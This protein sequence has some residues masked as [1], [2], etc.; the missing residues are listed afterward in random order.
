[1][2]A[3]SEGC[4]LYYLP[5]PRR[6]ARIAAQTPL[7]VVGGLA[8]PAEVDGSRLDVDVHQV[9][10]DLALDVVLNAVDEVTASHVDHLDER[11][12]PGRSEPTDECLRG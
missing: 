2:C 4:P 1:M 12:L 8:V 7:Q 3:C 6:Q 10:D 5:A 11:Q 9:V